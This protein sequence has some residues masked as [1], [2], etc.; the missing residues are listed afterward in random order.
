MSDGLPLGWAITTIGDLCNSPQYG[1]TTTASYKSDGVKL[2]RSTDISDGSVDWDAVPYCETAPVEVAKYQLHPRDIVITRTGVGVGN[3][4]LL[5]G[6]P[7]AVFA[8]Y[9][10]RFAPYLL[11]NAKYLAY[12]LKSPS[13]WNAVTFGSAG[14]AQPN[15][16]AKKLA[17]IEVPLASRNTQDAIVAEIE[18]QFTRLD[19]AV[20]ALKRVQANLKRYRAAVLKAA[21]EGR[22]VP[23]EAELAR[24]EGRSYETGEQLLARILKERRAK[25]EA[26]QLVKMQAS[27]KPPKNDDW[28]KKYKEPAPPVMHQLP[29]LPDGWIWVSLEQVICSG[30]QN[31]LYKP[32]TAYGAGTPILRIDDYQFDFCKNREQ[33]KCLETSEEETLLYGLAP[34]DTILNRVNSPSHLGKCTVIKAQLCPCVFESNMMRF[35]VSDSVDPE[36]ITAVLQTTNGKARLTAN[37]KWAVNQA[38]INQE[39]VKQ[40]AIPLPPTSEQ[41]RILASVKQ[42]L[43]VNA[44]AEDEVEIAVGRA[45]RLRQSILKRAFEG[46]LVPQDPNDEPASALLERIRAEQQGL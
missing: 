38:S 32:S 4:F 2:L 20:V 39:D 35:R 44:K 42:Q 41:A 31:G 37:A 22:L 6:C 36:W 19:A 43:S 28:T 7:T 17:S 45:D 29:K 13:Y 12:F 5:D 46:K 40:T 9:M 34:G 10:I 25:W 16:N 24:K 18:K 11:V 8:S 14:I 27:G 21:C 15:I 33:L 1:W 3:S 30:P 23:T 26:A